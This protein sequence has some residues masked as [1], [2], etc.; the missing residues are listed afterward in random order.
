MFSRRR[1]KKKK[2][3]QD[4]EK[5]E[6]QKTPTLGG[7]NGLPLPPKP[8]HAAMYPPHNPPKSLKLSIH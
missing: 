3:K 5:A 7:K 1:E 2:K 6:E 4:E 8:K